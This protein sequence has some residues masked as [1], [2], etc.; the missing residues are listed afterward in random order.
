[1]Y[2]LFH[3]RTVQI[4]ATTRTVFI[5]YPVPKGPFSRETE[6]NSRTCRSDRS[7]TN[8]RVLERVR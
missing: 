5:R 6:Y 7:R 8:N 1:M 4:V 3:E 2:T